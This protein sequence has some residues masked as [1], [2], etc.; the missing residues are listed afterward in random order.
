VGL[1]GMSTVGGCAETSKPVS[2]QFVG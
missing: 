2:S 1:T